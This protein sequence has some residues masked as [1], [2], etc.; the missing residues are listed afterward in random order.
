LQLY[1]GMGDLHVLSI[2][3]RPRPST[4]LPVRENT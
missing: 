3:E 2:L 1:G 4:Q